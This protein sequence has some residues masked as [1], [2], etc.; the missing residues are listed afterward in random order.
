MPELLKGKLRHIKNFK[1][2]WVKKKTTQIGQCQTESDWECSAHRSLGRDRRQLV[3][4]LLI[5]YGLKPTWLFVT[6]CP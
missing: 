1:F 3:R 5:V 2:I 6:G 4:K